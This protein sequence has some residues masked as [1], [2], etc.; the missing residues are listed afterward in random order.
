MN[1]EPGLLET[2][3]ILPVAAQLT[4]IIRVAVARDRI[5]NVMAPRLRELRAALAAQGIP[6]I[7]PW[8]NHHLRLD[9]DV[10]DFEI[11]FPVARRIAATGRI[12]SAA[13]PAARVARLLHHGRYEG[14]S[15]TWRELE[16]WIEARGLTPAANLWECYVVGPESNPDPSAWRTELNRPLV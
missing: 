7:G 4:A 13:L 16:A 10:F 8:F 11:G 3:R 5:R 15:S 2:P 12:E 6:P 9:P 14:L 1:R